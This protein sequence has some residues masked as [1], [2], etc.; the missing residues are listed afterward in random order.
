MGVHKSHYSEEEDQKG[1]RLRDD[2]QVKDSEE[3]HIGETI[4]SK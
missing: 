2:F 3:I 4:P 1:I